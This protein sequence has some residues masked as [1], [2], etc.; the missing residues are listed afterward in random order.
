MM[1]VKYTCKLCGWSEQTEA[2][3]PIIHKC[4]RY[5]LNKWNKGVKSFKELESIS[6]YALIE[7]E[8]LKRYK[9]HYNGST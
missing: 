4:T 8:R 3:P 7:A 5:D 1:V 6:K 2:K 9:D